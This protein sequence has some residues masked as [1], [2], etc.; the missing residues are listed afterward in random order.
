[1]FYYDKL[2]LFFFGKIYSCDFLM[3]FLVS[4]VRCLEATLQGAVCTLWWVG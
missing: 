3:S 4:T 1:M 2:L